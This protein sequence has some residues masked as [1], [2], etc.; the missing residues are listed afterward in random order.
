MVFRVAIGPAVRA[1]RGG[2]GAA[3]LER[4]NALLDLAEA[5]VALGDLL[6]VVER[7]PRISER[8]VRSPDLEVEVEG[9]ELCDPFDVEALLELG[10]G[11]A[12]LAALRLAA[13][14]HE[15]ALDRAPRGVEDERELADG[16]V[17]EAH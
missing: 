3:G 14:D 7:L 6:V 8:L 17:V 9:L 15:L 2:G 12:E 16:L 11:L 13:A 10:D 5:R 1:R 4:L